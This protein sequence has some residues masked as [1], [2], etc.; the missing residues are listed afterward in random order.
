MHRKHGISELLSEEK[1]KQDKRKLFKLF[2]RNPVCYGRYFYIYFER[3]SK[4]KKKLLIIRQ[5][6]S[7]L[8]TEDNSHQ[9]WP[10]KGEENRKKKEKKKTL[11]FKLPV[12]FLFIC[13]HNTSFLFLTLHHERC[14]HWRSL[15]LWDEDEDDHGDSGMNYYCDSYSRH[16]VAHRPA[17]PSTAPNRLET[18]EKDLLKYFTQFWMV[19]RQVMTENIRFIWSLWLK[20]K[21]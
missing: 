8:G 17:R 18:E 1:L 6:I 21:Y 3:D 19:A 15:D 9:T 5:I 10:F 13:C 12:C 11:C 7:C 2:K 4:K 16:S 14:F 20:E